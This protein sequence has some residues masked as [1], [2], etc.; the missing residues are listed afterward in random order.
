MRR[1]LEILLPLR[2]P[3][4]KGKSEQT[5]CARLPTDRELLRSLATDHILEG[6]VGT[7]PLPV[8]GP[9]HRVLAE[10]KIQEGA[11]SLWPWP[12]IPPVERDCRLIPTTTS[13]AAQANHNIRTIVSHQLASVHRHPRPFLLGLV[14]RIFSLLWPLLRL[15]S[16]GHPF[17][18]VLAKLDV[19]QFLLEQVHS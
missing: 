7:Y 4:S 15:P 10:R 5:E 3:D 1:Y 17:T 2:A 12:T 19:Y 18:M 8:L 11:H 13:L 16:R 14:V 9:L 6:T